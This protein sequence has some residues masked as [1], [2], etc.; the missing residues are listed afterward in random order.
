MATA[1]KHP[2]RFNDAVL[3][4][5]GLYL[6]G[7]AWADPKA[8]AIRILDPMAGAGRVHE[9]GGV[10]IQDAGMDSEPRAVSF[11]TVGV[12]LEPEWAAAHPRTIVGDA[13][14]LPFADITF[15]AI[16]VSPTYGNRMADHHDA[17][18]VCKNCRGQGVLVVDPGETDDPIYEQCPKC[19]GEGRRDYKR[20]TYRHTLDRPLHPNNSGSLQWSSKYQTFHVRAW[21]EAAR[22]TKP[23]G[24][25]LFNVSNHIRGGRL[26]PVVGFHCFALERTG[27]EVQTVEKV[28]TPRLR[29]GANHELRVDGERLIVA[30][31]W[32]LP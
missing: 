19:G 7:R 32:E 16:V 30:R 28:D 5:A 21:A 24:L 4:Q 13:L 26:M 18:E 12:E 10:T 9:L 6:L 3:H 23:G 29:Q 8:T 15:D 2:A 11:E 17:K 27:W 14:R 20:N 22:V 31:R 1:V 25:G